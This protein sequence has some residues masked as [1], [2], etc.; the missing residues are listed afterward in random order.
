MRIKGNEKRTKGGTQWRAK[1]L[2]KGLGTHSAQNTTVHTQNSQI[3]LKN[4][5]RRQGDSGMVD[6]RRKNFL[7]TQEVEVD[8][9][10]IE[11]N[12]PFTV[13]NYLVY[14]T[15]SITCTKEKKRIRNSLF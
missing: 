13:V 12:L 15:Q 8:L 2:R 6:I 7:W 9:A 11:H 10:T 4:A 1:G 5:N 14:E 3:K